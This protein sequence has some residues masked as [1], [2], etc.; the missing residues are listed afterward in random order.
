MVKVLEL[1]L[2]DACLRKSNMINSSEALSLNII[3]MEQLIAIE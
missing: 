3:G 2:L 1:Y